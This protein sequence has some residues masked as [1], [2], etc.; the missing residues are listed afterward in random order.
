MHIGSVR[1]ETFPDSAFSYFLGV[2]TLRIKGRK[3]LAQIAYEGR[4]SHP[5]NTSN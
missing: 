4:L 5:W 3:V 1:R 2:E